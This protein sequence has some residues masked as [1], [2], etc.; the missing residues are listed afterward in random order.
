MKKFDKSEDEAARITVRALKELG[1]SGPGTGKRDPVESIKDW[2]DKLLADQKSEQAKEWYN[3][4]LIAPL[5]FRW[6]GV[7]EK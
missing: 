7:F 2:R 4:A 6:D 3:H 1:R 5:S